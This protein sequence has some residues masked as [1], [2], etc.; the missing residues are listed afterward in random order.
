MKKFLAWLVSLFSK[1]VAPIVKAPPI[2]PKPETPHVPEPVTIPAPRTKASGSY[3][4]FANVMN[5]KMPERGIYAKGSPLGAIVHFTAGHDGA[6][7]TILGGIKNKYTYWCIQRNGDLY[8]AHRYNYWGW[9]AGESLWKNLLGS[10]S[11]DLIG[12]EMNAAGRL[13]RQKD[14]S[15]KTWFNTTIPLSEVRYVDGKSPDQC[16]GHYHVYTPAQEAT[17]I[18]TLLWLKERNP[19]VFDLNNV[20]GHCEVSGKLGLGRWRKND[21]S[22]ALSMTM[23]ALRSK[24]KNEWSKISGS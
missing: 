2:S 10:V 4:P 12:I 6:A 13:T 7:K 8:C 24:L 18:K 21:P 5:E 11:D 14:G 1:P 16:E 15:F 23:P 19:N 3:P 20:L 9:H 22:G 17:L